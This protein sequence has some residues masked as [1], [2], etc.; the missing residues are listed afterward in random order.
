MTVETFG[1]LERDIQHIL[2]AIKLFPEIE[3]AMIFG[4]RALGNYKIG[5]D[6]DIA[7]FGENMNLNIANR[8]KG[9]LNEELPIP[10]FIDVIDVNTLR[11]SDLKKHIEQYGITLYSRESI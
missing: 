7:C 8:L 11:N 6:I 4:S 1:L 9:K 3:K 5:S 10:F 2:S